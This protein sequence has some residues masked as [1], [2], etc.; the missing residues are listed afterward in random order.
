MVKGGLK[1]YEKPSYHLFII[2][3]IELGFIEIS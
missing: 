1:L 3:I 2:V